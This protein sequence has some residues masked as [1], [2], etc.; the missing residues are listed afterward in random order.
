MSARMPEEVQEHDDKE[1]DDHDRASIYEH[2]DGADELRVQH[3]IQGRETKH[4]V[5][6]PQRGRDGTLTRHEKSTADATAMNP[7]R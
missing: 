2:L 6:Q 4:R 1:K 5:H 7:N 3:D